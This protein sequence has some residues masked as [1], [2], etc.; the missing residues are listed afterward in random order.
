VHHVVLERADHLETGAV[1][2]MREP[3]VPMTAEVALED[4]A[5]LRPIEER[6]PFFEL[7]H[8]IGCLLRVQLRH[9]PV[10]Q[11]LAAA[12]GVAEVDLPV[13]LL[14]DV[15]HR[16][17]DPALG[18]DRVCFP[19]ERLADERGLH[20]HRARFDRRAKAGAA[21]ADHDDV[22]VVGLVLRH[23]ETHRR[24]VMTPIATSRM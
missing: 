22:V 8:A 24:S 5:I 15:A 20:A 16:R 14:P 13:V 7:E 2:D 3:R 1:A 18:H 9:A 21:C 23:Y 19:E 6:T 10:V 4:E 17:G 11:Q 12:H